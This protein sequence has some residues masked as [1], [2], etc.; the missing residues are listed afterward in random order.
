MVGPEPPVHL[1][2]GIAVPAAG[3]YQLDPPHTFAYFAAQ[4]L[5]VG[6]VRGHFNTLSG[7][8]R[9]AEDPLASSV[10]VRIETASVD[11]QNPR[12]DEELRSPR[13]L[14]VGRFPAMTYRATGVTPALDGRWTV[15]GELTVRAVTHP[16]RLH[17]AFIGAIVDPSNQV[18]IAFQASAAMSRK[19]FH[20]TT[21][22]ERES[23][24]VLFG[25]D[26][27]VEIQAEAIREA[28]D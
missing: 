25:R 19:D 8:V 20:L 9:I 10:D 18:R 21:E 4:H 23:G 17:G 24:G 28:G 2:D 3:T 12:R 14:D 7:A 6:R 11:T 16:V 13:Y 5:V 27:S 1:F 15:D 26:I 22:L